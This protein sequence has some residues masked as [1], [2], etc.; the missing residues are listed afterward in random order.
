MTTQKDNIDLTPPT[1]EQATE[2]FNSLS[3]TDKAA[4]RQ[5][6]MINAVVNKKTDDVDWARLSDSAF[7]A[8]RMKRFGF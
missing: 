4:V 8:E 3:D 7:L 6:Q 1:E 2:W 5:Q